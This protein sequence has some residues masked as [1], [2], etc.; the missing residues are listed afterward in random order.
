[1][2]RLARIPSHRWKIYS[3]NYQQGQKQILSNVGYFNSFLTNRELRIEIAERKLIEQALRKSEEKYKG[4]YQEMKA[5][6]QKDPLTGLY[7]HGRINELLEIEIERAK[8]GGEIFSIIMLDI[9]DLKLI[10]DTYGHIVGD[11]LLKDVATILRDSSRFVDS[12]GRYGGDEFL[13]ILPYTDGEEAKALAK[14]ISGQMKQEGFKI[15]AETNVPIR[16]SI[17]V[18]TY[19]FDGL[20][21]QELLSLADQRMYESKRSGKDAVSASVHE[22]SEFLTAKAPSFR[23]LQG[24]IAAVDSKDYYTRAHSEM[25][26]DHALSLAKEIGISYEQME[27]LKIASLLHDVGKIGVPDSILRKPGSL[28]RGE[29]EIIKQHPQLG[30]MMVSNTSLRPKDVMGAIMHHHGRYDGKGYPTCVGGEDIPLLARIIAIADSYSAMTTDRPYRNAMAK[31]EALEELKKNAGT[32]F[33]PNL[34]PRF[35]RCLKG[36]ESW[37]DF[38]LLLNPPP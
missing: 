8:R 38:I 3:N 15:D 10:N 32:Q 27:A 4:L 35:T 33:D 19:L 14:R 18:A 11:R 21:A 7:N 30:A 13:M 12:I 5:L 1:M 16:L 9:D 29:F 31:D 22:L 25:V 17:G 37:G 2:K 23:I 24:I 26:T 34:V 36:D 6:A 20:V 28:E